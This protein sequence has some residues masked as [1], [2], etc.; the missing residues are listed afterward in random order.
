MEED[1]EPEMN[2]IA[3]GSAYV[4]T[5][6]FSPERQ[7]S[8]DMWQVA[9]SHRDHIVL[10]RLLCVLFTPCCSI[11]Y[12]DIRFPLVVASIEETAERYSIPKPFIGLILLPIVVRS[13]LR[14]RSS[15]SLTE[16]LQPGECRRA[17]HVG[18][19][20]NEEQDGAHHRHLCW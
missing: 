10:R 15:P 1:E 8:K 7:L 2:T 19:D 20:G 14:F 4:L 18:V 3:A 16:T 13:F 12:V 5:T 11:S 6:A 9:P 17:R